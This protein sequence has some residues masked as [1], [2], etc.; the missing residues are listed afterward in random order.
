MNISTVWVRALGGRMLV[1]RILLIAACIVLPACKT[2]GGE[3]SSILAGDPFTFSELLGGN[4]EDTIRDVAVDDQGNV[5]VVGG[6]ASTNLPATSAAYDRSLNTSGSP[7][8]DAFVAKFDEAGNLLWC[9]YLGGPNYDRAYAVEVDLAGY[10][11]V[12]GRAGAGFP[13]TTGVIQPAFAGDNDANTLYGNQDGFIAKLSPD[14]RT[15]LWSTYLGE[16]GRGFIRDIALMPDCELNCDVYAVL[17]DVREGSVT[18]ITAG[19]YDTT[20]NGGWDSVVAHIRNDGRQV[21][22]A[23]YLG[24]SGIDVATPSIRVGS[25]GRVV[26][27]GYTDSDDM[28]VTLGAFDRT[29]NGG[30]DLH[31]AAFSPEGST[32]LWGTY[33]GGSDVEFT[34]THALAMDCADNVIVAATTKSAD[35]P[36]SSGAFQTVYGGSAGSGTGSGT[37]YPGDGFVFILS[38]DGH[39]RIAS[40]FLGGSGGEGLEGV[41]VDGG[42]DVL[43]AGGTYSAD[44]PVSADAARGQYQGH[45]D[46]FG[47][48]LSPDLSDRKYA[49]YLGG[50]NVD[51]GRA[52][53]TDKY[54]NLYIAGHSQSANFP[55][56]SPMPSTYQA[57][58]DGAVAKLEVGVAW[59]P[60]DFEGNSKVD[61]KDFASFYACLTPCDVRHGST[62]C[63]P[64]DL[65]YDGILDLD[66]FA[67]LATIV[68]GPR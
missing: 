26:V 21:I 1:L 65:T 37:N 41:A 64:G 49:T 14:G 7:I 43:V 11:Y 12:A 56:V 15:L 55:I 34:E 8:H 39:Q 13:V 25:D 24:G 63:A 30:G 33:I 67:L 6:T 45:G 29:Y 35:F 51:Y 32:L 16:V 58:W 31:V 52:V 19:A 46:A 17:T 62:F 28:P 36:V 42:G 66:D 5:I 40:T 9:T 50:T 60:G 22:W 44:F 18:H 38:A 10:V 47:A 68:T 2:R 4:D 54:G 59:G 57:D 48:V 23:T 53:A 27:T 3:S 20:F 61:L